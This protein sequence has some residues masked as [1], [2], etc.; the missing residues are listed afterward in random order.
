M[1]DHTDTA[2]R[3]TSNRSTT[4]GSDSFKQY[5]SSGWA[6]RTD[7]L[8]PA[9]EQAAYAAERRARISA[10]YPGK[11][12]IVPAGQLKQR[13]ND[14]DFPFRGH[15]AFTYLTG[16]GADSEPGSV[17]V[18]EPVGSASGAGHTADSAALDN[19]DGRGAR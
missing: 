7:A 12:L 11:R 4:P 10:L 8:P 13:S 16:W 14:T 19:A 6:E 5:I 1:A 2:P 15:T 3:A 17:L 18:L 9:R